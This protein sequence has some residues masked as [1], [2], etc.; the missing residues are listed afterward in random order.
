MH[1]AE[2][3]C[4]VTPY[5]SMASMK[6]HSELIEHLSRSHDAHSTTWTIYVYITAQNWL[7][8]IRCIRSW[9]D[10]RDCPLYIWARETTHNWD[11]SA[12]VFTLRTNERIRYLCEAEFSFGMYTT[13]D[14]ICSTQ[15]QF[16]YL[17]AILLLYLACE[18]NVCTNT[19][20]I[21]WHLIIREI[22]SWYL[23][24]AC[25]I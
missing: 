13:K 18:R 22:G 24:R 21:W 14:S 17:T 25:H 2:C 10:R 9:H 7:Q 3:V 15:K 5:T 23:Y 11:C 4:P 20:I 1:I 19:E 8:S 6:K 12:Y 16:T